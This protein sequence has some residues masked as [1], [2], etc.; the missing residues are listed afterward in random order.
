MNFCG[1]YAFELFPQK[2]HPPQVKKIIAPAHA[3]KGI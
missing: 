2:M 3:V 1:D